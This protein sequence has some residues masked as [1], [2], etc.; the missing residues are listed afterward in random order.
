MKLLA[1]EKYIKEH[2]EELLAAYKELDPPTQMYQM[3]AEVRIRDDEIA[4]L[5][6]QLSYA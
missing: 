5:K 4:R 1:D 3:M 2:K 6:L